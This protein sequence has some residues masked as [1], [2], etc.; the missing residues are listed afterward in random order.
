EIVIATGSGLDFNALQLRLHPA[1]SRVKKLAGETPASFVAF[2]LLAQDDR[3]LRSRTQ[4]ERRLLLEQALP[5]SDGGIHLTPC[6]RDRALA[7]EWFHRFEGA[8]LDGVVAKH[9]STLYQPGKRAMIKVKHV[10]TAD[11]VV[12]GFRW[13]KQGA[14]TLVGSLLLG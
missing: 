8:G 6:S 12:G 9:E 13:Y 7:G 1:A 3:D 2:D 10:R 4:A 5:R 14:G 11:C